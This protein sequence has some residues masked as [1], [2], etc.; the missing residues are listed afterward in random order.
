M[1]ADNHNAF[2]IGSPWGKKEKGSGMWHVGTV[3]PCTRTVTVTRVTTGHLPAWWPREH[4]I[5]QLA[6][7]GGGGQ[8]HTPLEGHG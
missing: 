6:R 8:K 7:G 3:E 2:E 5:E 4:S 1:C